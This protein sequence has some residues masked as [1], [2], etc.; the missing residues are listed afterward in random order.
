MWAVTKS[1]S[2]VWQSKK[3]Q[4]D[5]PYYTKWHDLLMILVYRLL[6][7]WLSIHRSTRWRHNTIAEVTV[8]LLIAV[9]HSLRIHLWKTSGK[10]NWCCLWTVAE[11]D[12]YCT[13]GCQSKGGGKCDSSCQSGYSQNTTDYTC[14]RTLL[15]IRHIAVSPF[16]Y[17]AFSLLKA[18]EL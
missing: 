2:I 8:R 4:L 10:F 3:T 14:M 6:H 1:T 18:G 17:R 13:S 5:P 16:L 15:I 9:F 12:P 11:C 7:V